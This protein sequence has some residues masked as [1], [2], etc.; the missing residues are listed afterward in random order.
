M[1]TNLL[2]F[3]LAAVKLM[4]EQSTGIPKVKGSCTDAS[5]PGKNV[6]K[7]RFSQKADDIEVLLFL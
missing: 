3:Y 6:W 7:K 4:V 5:G 2:Y 1:I